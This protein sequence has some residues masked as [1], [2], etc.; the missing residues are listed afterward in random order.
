MNFEKLAQYLDPLIPYGYNAS[1][2]FHWT[3]VDHDGRDDG[4]ELHRHKIKEITGWD[5][6]GG[7]EH[8]FSSFCVRK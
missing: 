7:K 6:M 8:Y 3:D 4:V 2:V 5:E 1:G